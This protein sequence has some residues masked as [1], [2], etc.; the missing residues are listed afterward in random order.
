MRDSTA[1]R[2]RRPATRTAVVLAVGALMTIMALAAT[3]PSA[4]AAP[5]PERAAAAAPATVTVDARAGL[6][7]IPGTAYGINAAV[8]DAHM[9]DP[10]VGTLMREANIGLVRYPGGSYADIYHWRDNTA[11]G[12]FVAPGTDFDAFMGTVRAAGAQ[13][14]IIANYGSGTPQEAADWVRYANV[15]KGYGAKYWEIGNELYGNGHYGSA[16]E[17]DNHADK[18]PAG[19]ARNLLDFAAA[20]KA[21]D[22]SIKIGAVLTTPGNWPDGAV[23][24][25]DQGDWN[26]TVLSI[27]ADAID[28]VS[29][30]WYPNG[31]SAADT[32]TRPA[33][34]ADSVYQVR[35]QLER[36]AGDRAGAIGV[37]LTEVNASLTPQTTQMSALFAADNYQTW[38]ETGVFTV[39]WWNTHNGIGT[40]GTVDGVTDYADFGVLS[41]GTCAGEVC[42]PAVNTPFPA[43]FGIKMAG[44]LG[45]PGDTMVRAGSADPLVTAHAV[46][47]AN[48]ELSVMLINKDPAAAHTVSLAYTGFIPDGAPPVVRTFT[49]GATSI[50]SGTAGTGAVQ[51]VPPYS[52][53]TVDLHP[54]A[55]STGALAA[56][57]QAAAAT[58]TDTKATVSWPARQGADKYEV[59]RH[60]GAGAE[61]LG[62][63][64]GTSLPVANLRPGTAYALNVL[65]RDHDGRLSPPSA[66]VRF[67]TGTPADSTCAV[68]YRVTNAWGTG[69]IGEIVITNRGPDPITGWTLGFTFPAGSESVD[70]GWNGTW[71]ETGRDVKV[72]PADFNMTLAAGGGTAEVGFVGANDGAYPSPEAFTLNGTLCTTTTTM[73]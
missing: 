61:L 52:I 29:V 18:S 15:T 51:T 71:S 73:T 4:S 14:I 49:R 53:A 3:A 17:T 39:D 9:N 68:S 19:Y 72:T 67:T 30:H 5:A 26:H 44:T 64:S 63:T 60:T 13:P 58:V 21:V 70:S 66:P 2:P 62:T 43:Y 27:V 33:L 54:A 24:D 7:T 55:G 8:W 6:G 42:E 25:G 37:A 10:A 57:A 28:F 20:M 56:P 31:S 40:V 45:R 11:P 41:S 59:Y 50:T 12:G 69:F 32:L 36:Y 23:A 46:R 1:P 35:R 65:A 48:G 34:V 22:P 38:L 16:W 47:H